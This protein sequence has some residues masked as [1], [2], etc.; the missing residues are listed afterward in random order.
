MFPPERSDHRLIPRKRLRRNLNRSGRAS[1]PPVAFLPRTGTCLANLPR[2]SRSAVP[3][4]ARQLQNECTTRPGT[5]REPGEADNSDGPHQ[6]TRPDPE[7]EQQT[8][9]RAD[10]TDQEEKRNCRQGKN[11]QIG[12]AGHAK[13]SQGRRKNGRDARQV[14]RTQRTFRSPV[15]RILPALRRKS[16]RHA[17]KFARPRESLMKAA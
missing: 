5:N 7:T 3:H 16:C 13:H 17:G 8:R 12:P 9:E 4:E 14:E 1:S 11:G 6:S 2:A 10:Q 15:V